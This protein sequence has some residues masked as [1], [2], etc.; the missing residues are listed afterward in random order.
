MANVEFLAIFKMSY[1]NLWTDSKNEE[2]GARQ[3]I[4][5]LT[6]CTSFCNLPIEFIYLF[7]ISFVCVSLK[8]LITIVLSPF[9]D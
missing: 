8:V 3:K 5:N 7:T 2:L 4:Q 1:S 6:D 9:I